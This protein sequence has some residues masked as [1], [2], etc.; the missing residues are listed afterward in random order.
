MQRLLKFLHIPYEEKALVKA[1]ELA[2]FDNM[3]KMELSGNAPRYRTSGFKIFATG[4]L[5][6]QKSYFV[7]QG[8]FREYREHLNP[9]QQMILES[10]I[11][12]QLSPKYGYD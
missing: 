12:N 1:I 6:D 10:T 11:Q 3:R 5:N 4:D 9:E 7:R 2:S 8:K